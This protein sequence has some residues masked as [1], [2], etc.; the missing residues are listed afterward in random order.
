[1]IPAAI[2][3]TM[4]QLD[5]LP[6]ADPGGAADGDL[7]VIDVDYDGEDLDAVA[8]ATAMPSDEVVRRHSA[9]TYRAEFCGFAPGFAYLAG[10]DPC[11]VLPRRDTPRSDSSRRSEMPSIRLSRTRSAMSL[12]RLLLMT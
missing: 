1:M 9:V 11:L 4:H 3:A 6:V 8:A 12:I 2:T 7:V 5:G 10:L